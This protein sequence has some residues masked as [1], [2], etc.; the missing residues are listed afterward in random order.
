MWPKGVF[1]SSRVSFWKRRGKEKVQQLL[2]IVLR[3]KLKA[4]GCSFATPR[5]N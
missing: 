4:K 3:D 2:L 5:I 1:K